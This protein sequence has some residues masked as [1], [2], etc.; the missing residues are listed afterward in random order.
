MGG[1][2][3]GGGSVIGYKYLLGMHM[4]ICYGPVDE[5]SEIQVGQRTAWQGSLT[6]SQQIY[7]DQP[8]LFGGEKK[9]GGIQGHVDILFGEPTQTKNDYL[10]SQ[11][12]PII[13]AFRSM[14]SA[15]L[16]KC[17][18][19]AMSPYPKPW[20]FLVKRCPARSWY[21]AKA[22]IN[23]SANPAHIIYDVLTNLDWG[24]GYPT[25]TID[26]ASF[27]AVADTLYAEGLGLS[28]LLANEDSIEKF[29]YSVMDHINAMFYASPIDGKFVI[30][31]LRNDYDIAT[32]PLFD[33]TN[34]TKLE[35]YERPSFAEMVNE[36]VVNYRPQGTQND[37]SVTIQNLA[38][39]QAQ[40]GVIS[41]SVNYPGIDTAANAARV[42][43]RDLKLKSTPLCRVRIHVNR[44]AWDRTIGDC[45]KFSWA[46]HGVS[47]MVLRILS[48]DSGLLENGEMVIDCVEDIFG[49]PTTTYIGNQPSGWADPVQLPSDLMYQKEL[50]ATYYDVM[51]NTTQA[52]QAYLTATSAFLTTVAGQPVG[53]VINYELW[54]EPY[55]GTYAK[56]ADGHFCPIGV[57]T[58][59]LNKVATS[60]SV[61]SLQGPFELFSVGDYAIVGNEIL[62][63]DTI[64]A[65]TGAITFGRGCLDSI[66]ALHSAGDPVYFVGSLLAYDTVEYAT[67][68]TVYARL[69][70][71]TGT[72]VLPLASATQNSLVMQGR[73][74][75]PYA[76][77]QFKINGQYYPTAILGALALAWAHRDRTQQLA[78]IIDFT[79]GN[80]GPEAGT[81]YRCRIYN[82]DG[83]LVHDDATLTGTSYSYTTEET[84]LNRL[85]LAPSGISFQILGG[86]PAV[87]QKRLNGLFRVKLMSYRDTF[88][89]ISEYDELAERAGYGYTY[90]KYYGGI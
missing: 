70:P 90:G 49:M 47:G 4:V 10:M 67:G 7:I 3:K 82:E 41:Q 54:T 35:N 53:A 81:T 86:P 77:G 31:L 51:R 22:E 38:A 71:R 64:D 33:E 15:V 21:A 14:V 78:N 85:V 44:T 2:G 37:D 24:L 40:Q 56:A 63:I 1:G 65:T 12:G 58:A 8:E 29:I 42:A 72:G 87:T 79:A 83:V 45:I 20:A 11:L 66:P 39:V 89:S 50:E 34:I 17:Y 30:K 60:A 43:M 59:N 36:I 52:D 61:G 80:I 75:R 68:E 13:P 48:I 74:I 27:R 18:V 73:M 55:G 16:R 57:L 28:M 6:S 25:S 88:N 9:E 62:R 76:P 23:K 5:I 69:L 26:D 32:L 19:T 84:D 46:E